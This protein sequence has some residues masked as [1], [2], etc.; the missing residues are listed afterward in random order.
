[1]FTLPQHPLV[2]MPFSEIAT[3]FSTGTIAFASAGYL[4]F[5]I[6]SD[7]GG[8]AT[9]QEEWRDA[10]ARSVSLRVVEKVAVAESEVLPPQGID[11]TGTG[12]IRNI[13]DNAPKETRPKR[14]EQELT[15]LELIR[16]NSD[17]SPGVSSGT[18]RVSVIVGKGDTLFAISQRHGIGVDALARLNGLQEPYV[19]KVGQT[20]YLA[21]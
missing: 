17:V 2:M 10:S 18:N 14:A 3:R 7:N 5:A 13:A 4:V 8:S 16:K 19:I 11:Q 21:R 20:L 6:L 1:M 15:V 9:S 12:S